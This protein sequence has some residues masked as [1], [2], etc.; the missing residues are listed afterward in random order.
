V[1]NVILFL[2]AAKE[3]NL[4]ELQRLVAITIDKENAADSDVMLLLLYNFIMT[5]ESNPAVLA[6]YYGPH[7]CF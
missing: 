2:K 6:E 1:L 3:D 4:A 5:D 7:V